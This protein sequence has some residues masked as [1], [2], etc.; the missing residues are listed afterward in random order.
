MITRCHGTFTREELDLEK[1]IDERL[2]EGRLDVL[3]MPQAATRVLTMIDSDNA[4][5]AGIAREV[6]TDQGITTH[7]LSLANSA[8]YRGTA[9]ITSI[10]QAV[11]RLGLRELKGAV[12]MISLRNVF[13]NKTHAKLSKALWQHSLATAI[14][15]RRIG[16]I[17]QVAKDEVFTAGLVH[18]VGKIVVLALYESLMAGDDTGIADEALTE[19]VDEFHI[20]AGRLLARDWD[21]PA[22]ATEAII[23][24]HADLREIHSREG[25]AVALANKLAHIIGFASPGAS[26]ADENL[27]EVCQELG[28]T[29]E[30]QLGLI[31]ETPDLVAQLEAITS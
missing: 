24:H 23:T 10:E 31:E 9:T 3:A 4:T 20:D 27:D 25:R 19:I 15:A 13:R 2:A 21:L 5:I 6:G 26:E 17:A 8:F 12:L 1:K 22:V 16:E 30:M 28:I 7:I 14:L 18:D 11:I 29:A